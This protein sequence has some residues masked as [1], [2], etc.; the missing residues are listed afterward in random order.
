[1]HTAHLESLGAREIARREFS[2][3]VRELIDYDAPP[4]RWTDH[5]GPDRASASAD[6]CRS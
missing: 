5:A 4:G 2:R 6:P 3:K 1:M